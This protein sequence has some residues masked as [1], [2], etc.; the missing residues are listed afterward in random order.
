V[1]TFKKKGGLMVSGERTDAVLISEG[2]KELESKAGQGGTCYICCHSFRER[3]SSNIKRGN[4]A[5]VPR[6]ELR[7]RI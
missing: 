6:K 5:G 1:R 7:N 2:E 4:T 3:M